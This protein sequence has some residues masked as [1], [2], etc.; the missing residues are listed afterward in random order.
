MALVAYPLFT[1]SLI[2]N[3]REVLKPTNQYTKLLVNAGD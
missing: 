1:L 3:Y 2:Y